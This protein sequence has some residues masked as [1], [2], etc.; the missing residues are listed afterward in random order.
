MKKILILFAISTLI[1][2]GNKTDKL[3]NFTTLFE[4]SN[5]T[6][7]N[8]YNEVISF[9]KNLDEEFAGVSLFSFGQT[10]SGEPLHL[11]VYSQ[12][13]I[14]NVSEI[15]KSTKNRILINNGIHPGES[16]GIDASMMLIRDIVKNDSL[17]EKY[18]N[19]IIC[20]I[21]VYNIG[22]ALNRNSHTRAN[23]NGPKEYG[24]RGNAR[25]YDLN[26]DFIKQDTKNAAAFA[27][28]FHTVNPDVFIDNHVSNGA[29]Y[30][31]AIT[32]LFTQHNKLGGKLGIFLE[33][34]MRPSLEKSL[35]KKNIDITPYVNVWGTTP[36]AGFSQFFDSPRYST[37]YTTLF[38]T[39]GLMVETHMLKPYKIRVEQ[40][41]ELLFSAL[42]F[43]KENSS[44]I[45]ELRK[46]AV[47][48]VLSKNTYPI[49]FK[50][51]KENPTELQFK[52]FE[53]E[54]IESKVTNG[55]RLFY[56]TAKP[57]TKPIK[58]YNNF[59]E[60]KSIKIPKAYILQ[61]G[62]HKVL[63]RLKNNNIQFSKLK[64]DTIITVEV[65]HI[66]DFKTRTNAYEGHYLHYNTTVSSSKKEIKF[67]KGDLYIETNQPGVRY[68]L[69]TLEA[70]AT[71][72]F[73]NWN[74][75]DTILQQKEGYS[76]Y[77]FE[78][79][80]EEIL[81]SN[82]EIKKAFEEKL[83][84]DIKFAENPRMQLNFI[85]KNSAY[86]ETAHLRLPVFK[87]F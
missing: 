47:A 43:T 1:S 27:E 79:I 11:V 42:D 57:Y 59:V 83:K 38:N 65:N 10:D 58:Y 29:D 69:E 48:E 12:E 4:K 16:D 55:K 51:D 9:Y 2:C 61:Q 8:E 37:G 80:A 46:N 14:Y 33:N 68:L 63:D 21:P 74:F 62:W 41:Y 15:K 87:I 5:G 67:R 52:G 85:Y 13:E 44:K 36:E 40:T 39:L 17:K 25:N 3:K 18:K 49:A 78:D 75:F 76:S 31:Y 45:K 53:G 77:V 20:V 73:F 54:Y 66:L 56:D 50:V 26:R 32:H 82:L 71:D 86:Y 60:S 19:S 7:T 64:N 23:Q 24:F 35:L 84:S 72:S 34:E 70:E 28:I 22:G 30:Q 6:E 81:I